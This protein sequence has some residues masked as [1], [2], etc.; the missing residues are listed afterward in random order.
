[1]LLSQGQPAAA[2][3]KMPAPDG[4]DGQ[5]PEVGQAGMLFPRHTAQ[6]RRAKC[7]FT[8]ISRSPL[9]KARI[10]SGNAADI[11]IIN[12]LFVYFQARPRRLATRAEWRKTSF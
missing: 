2:R 5:S 1:M 10:I 11:R 3:R 8:S 12:A 4:S 7:Y 6:H 9:S